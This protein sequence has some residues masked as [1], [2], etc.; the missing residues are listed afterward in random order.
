MDDTKSRIS[1]MV[2]EHP[3]VLFM[4]GNRGAPR[5]GFSA[6]VV[7]TL[8][9]Y[10]PDYVTV[11]VLEDPAVRE[12][13]KAFSSWPTIPQLYVKGE[14]V[15]GCDIV[16]EMAENGELDEVLG[17]KRAEIA[18]PEVFVTPA[19]LDALQKFHEGEGTP[20][21]RLDINA[22]WQYGMDFDDPKASDIVV[23][24]G[25]WKVVMSRASALRAN[26]LTIDFVD[27]AGGG[28]FKIDNPNE[29]PKVK[30]LE[31]A[32]LKAWMDGGKPFEFFDVRG[33]DEREVAK[34]EGA[35]MLDPAGQKFLRALDRQKTLVFHCHHGMRSQR[36]AEMALQMGFTDVHNL[37]GGIDAWSRKVDS[38][39]PRY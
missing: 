22:A 2:Q 15:G 27:N 5:C 18:P 35:R 31:P 23:D 39:I 24:G 1:Q 33:T 28:G 19:G 34:I 16:T 10:L 13:I 26:G 6:K 4:K 21:I 3:V 37:A 17:I 14:F 30:L 20:C 12:G 9:E 38:T 25:A 7:G 29:P 32:E 8:D 11:D 36:A